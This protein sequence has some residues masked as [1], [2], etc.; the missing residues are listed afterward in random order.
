MKT[1]A[2]T[3][4]SILMTTLLCLL[5]GLA[6]AEIVG[7]T[8]DGYIHR[9]TADNG[10]DIYFVST[11]EEALVETGRDVNFDGH[12]DLAVVTALGASNAFYEFYL[13]NGSEYEYAE[14]W[15]SDI[16]NFEL[17]ADKYLVSRS[18]D[19]SAGMLFTAQICVWDGAI[20]KAIRTMVA[21]EE[22]T[23]DWE[24]GIATRR[25]DGNRL[26]A[27]LWGVD[28]LVGEAETLWEKTY[29][30]FPEDPDVLNEMESQLWNGLQ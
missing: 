28:G 3:F 8:Y 29:A 24:D 16:V 11:S 21:E 27:I 10:Q 15:T 12:S 14:R 30:P 20:L 26:H 5:P 17:V 13:W 9:Y 4:C 2:I 7:R 19:G 18:N 1:R 25:I 6:G 23:F 22:T